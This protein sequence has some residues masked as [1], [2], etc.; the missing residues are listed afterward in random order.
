[1]I[2]QFHFWIQNNNL[3]DRILSNKDFY[4]QQTIVYLRRMIE[5]FHQQS[6]AFSQDRRVSSRIVY[7]Q[8]RSYNLLRSYALHD[9]IFQAKFIMIAYFPRTI[10]YSQIIKIVDFP[11]FYT[12]SHDHILQQDRFQHHFEN[13]PEWILITA[14][15]R[16]SKLLFINF[17]VKF[18]VTSMLV[19]GFWGLVSLTD[20]GD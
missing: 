17:K 10:L 7:L 11:R 5:I 15:N 2:V 19:A 12:Y 8:S 3:E 20:V 13:V 6:Y 4:L 16:F 9:G 18:T 1:M 14:R